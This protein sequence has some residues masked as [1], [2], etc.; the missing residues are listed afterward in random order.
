[1]G[2][3]Y[4]IKSSKSFDDL[5]EDVVNASYPIINELYKY[6]FEDKKVDLYKLIGNVSLSSG[7]PLDD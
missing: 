5:W 6:V 4:S 2:S 3:S 1:M 7:L